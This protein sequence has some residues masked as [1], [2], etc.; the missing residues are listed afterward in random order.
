[1]IMNY[2][3][4]YVMIQPTSNNFAEIDQWENVEIVTHGYQVKIVILKYK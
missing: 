4:K 2:F 3:S 1:M